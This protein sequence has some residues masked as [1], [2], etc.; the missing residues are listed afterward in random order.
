[1]GCAN[2]APRELEARAIADVT[3]F[4]L[5]IAAAEE[6]TREFRSSATG[7]L[8]ALRRAA[9][10]TKLMGRVETVPVEE[11]QR[12]ARGELLARLD[13]RDL[14]A[15]V[16]QAQAGVS[17]AEAQ[18]QNATA[19]HE[20]MQALHQRGSVTDKNVEDALAQ[21]RVAE[22]AL[23]NAQAQL[24]AARVMLN[25]AQIRSPLDGWVTKKYLHVGDL[26]SP[27]ATA[28]EIEDLSTLEVSAEISESQLAQV[29]VGQPILVAAAGSEIEARITRIVPAG[30]PASRTFSLK[31]ELSDPAGTLRPGMFA[32]VSWSD[33]GAATEGPLQIPTR[34]LVR[35]GQLVGIFVAHPESQTVSLRWVKPGASEGEL[36]TVL[37]GL[38]A[39]ELLVVNPPADLFDGAPYR[40][41]TSG[42]GR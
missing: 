38:E 1:M 26:A 15:A 27:G 20:R 31:S 41:A 5:E 11:G 39:G 42:S 37:S 10:G 35:N 3:P 28:F 18:L 34:A 6:S 23:Q 4:E 13:S 14:E 7:T 21:Y 2:E 22:A 30:D 12:V 19:Q 29:T 24:D 9:P 40:P 16:N 32:R 25:Y 36:I 17:M 33:S 8:Q